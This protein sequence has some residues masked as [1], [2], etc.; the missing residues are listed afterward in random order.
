M[1][2]G[3]NRQRRRRLNRERYKAIEETRVQ[4]STTVVVVEGGVLPTVQN[5]HG[6]TKSTAEN[7]SVLDSALLGQKSV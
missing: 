5:V 7:S 3:F 6:S 4:W 1:I 2:T